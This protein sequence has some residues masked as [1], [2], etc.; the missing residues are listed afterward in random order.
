[1]TRIL[2][3]NYLVTP[4]SR[5]IIN[6]TRLCQS[7][8]RM[9]E[10]ACFSLFACAEGQFNM[11]PMH[12]IAG[13]KGDNSAPALPGELLSQFRRRQTQCSEIIAGR[14]LHALKPASDVPW[15]R[16]A[17]HMEDARMGGT[18]GIEYRLR[19]LT[20]IRFPHFFHVQQGQHHSF[21]IP[22]SNF[23]AS[24]SERFREILAYIKRNWNG[25]KNT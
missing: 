14:P 25:P 6:V 15:I 3:Q 18:G 8:C 11:G 16:F 20:A 9:N 23:A 4:D 13:L 19:F 24:S 7:Y 12:G 10:Q 21:G 17:K 22:K 5:E 1:S 2:R